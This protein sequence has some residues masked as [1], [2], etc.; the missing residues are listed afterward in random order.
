MARIIGN[1]IA[2]P[3]PVADW[4]QNDSTKADYIKNK[5]SI[6]NELLAESENPIQN[7]A[8]A[9]AINNLTELVGDSSVSEQ[10]KGAMDT[11]SQIQF[12]TWEEND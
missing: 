2:T 8:V 4:N 9:K 10:I 5:P 6:D 11:K 12:V 3:T 1:T 7:K